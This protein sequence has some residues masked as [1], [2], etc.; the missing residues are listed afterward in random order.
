MPTHEEHFYDVQRLDPY[1][2]TLAYVYKLTD[3]VF[4]NLAI[5]RNGFAHQA[6]FPPNVAHAEKRAAIV[7]GNSDYPFAP[8]QADQ[9]GRYWLVSPEGRY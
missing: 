5:A 9:A 8:L 1:G 7:V 3:G 6:T 4:V 2:R